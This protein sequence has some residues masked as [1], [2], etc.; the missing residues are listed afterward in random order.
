MPE[1]IIR[2]RGNGG[3]EMKDFF[4]Q[5]T[6]KMQKTWSQWEQM[7]SEFPWMNKSDGCFLRWNPGVATMRFTFD[8]NMRAWKT[9]MEQNEAAFFKM[10]KEAPFHNDLTEAQMRSA[11]ESMKKAYDT[12]QEIVDAQFQKMEE[13]AKKEA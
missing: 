6:K 4:E 5:S 11:W 9:F 3:D 10:L 1:K 8:M 7:V 2:T 12:Y 13:V